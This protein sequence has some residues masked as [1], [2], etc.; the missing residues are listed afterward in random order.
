MREIRQ[1][2]SEGG[3][4]RNQSALPTPILAWGEDL[5][6]RRPLGPGFAFANKRRSRTLGNRTL[7]RSG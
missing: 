4:S 1:S 6:S 3:G 7:T 5:I 2:G